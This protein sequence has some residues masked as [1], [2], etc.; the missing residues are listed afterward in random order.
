M[1]LLGGGKQL[2]SG[3]KGTSR[4]Y[5]SIFKF[6]RRNCAALYTE[7]EYEE[8]VIEAHYTCKGVVN[9][10]KN[11]YDFFCKHCLEGFK[12]KNAHSYYMIFCECKAWKRP[13]HLKMYPT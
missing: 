2:L 1:L 11:R 8:L 12:E 3:P 10:T 9:N 13:G 7:E 5:K 6:N 4:I